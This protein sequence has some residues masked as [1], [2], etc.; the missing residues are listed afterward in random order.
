MTFP[1]GVL[2]FLAATFFGTAMSA[3]IRQ[4]SGDVPLGQIIFWRSAT[5]LPP[6]IAYMA[7]CGDFPR[8]MTTRQPRLHLTRN[9]FGALSMALSFVSLTYLPVANAQALA[10]LTPVLTLPIAAVIAGERPGRR[11]ISALALGVVGV[12]VMIGGAIR[13]PGDGAAIGVAAGLGFAATMA[14][15]RVHIRG[16]TR[17]ERPATIAFYFGLTGSLIGLASWP[18]GWIAPNPTTMALLVTSGILGA[19]AHICATEAVAR[20]AVSTIAP[21][22][23]TGLIWALGFDILLLGDP[24]APASLAGAAVILL[25]VLVVA[26]SGEQPAGNK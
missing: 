12:S 4:V 7:L 18:F 20:T 6:I 8:A 2:L 26:R 16:M 5:A 13:M 1:R 11:V 14:F 24:P 25:A 21:L 15:V 22:E 10:Y 23:Y 17:S 3:C 9:L 19:F